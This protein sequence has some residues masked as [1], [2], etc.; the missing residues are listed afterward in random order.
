MGRGRKRGRQ[1]ERKGG[2]KEGGIDQ[3]ERCGRNDRRVR[4]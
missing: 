2:V 4:E 3:G 1:R